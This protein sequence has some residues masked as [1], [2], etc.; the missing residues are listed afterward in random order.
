MRFT[1]PNCHRSINVDPSLYGKALKCPKCRGKFIVDPSFPSGI[2]IEKFAEDTEPPEPPGQVTQTAATLPLAPHPQNPL[3]SRLESIVFWK[4]EFP[5]TGWNLFWALLILEVVGAAV[6]IV[7]LVGTR[8]TSETDIFLIL[9]IAA[10]AVIHFALWLYC[11]FW[12]A[13]ESRR[14]A[15]SAAPWL[16]LMIWMQALGFALFLASRPGRDE[17]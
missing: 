16:I 6:W 4:G 8:R 1:C 7:F 2:Q 10:M 5:H 13:K 12:V 9:M 15:E 11:L 3:A 17:V 14:Y